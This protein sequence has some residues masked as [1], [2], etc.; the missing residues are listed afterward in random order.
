MRY[1][2]IVDAT[3]ESSLM[4]PLEYYVEEEPSVEINAKI[5]E[6]QQVGSYNV[7]AN[8]LLLIENGELES[9]SMGRKYSRQTPRPCFNCNWP[10][11]I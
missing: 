10:R 8:T 11:R 9:T 5:I 3:S 6:I 2:E 1:V 4:S 7:D